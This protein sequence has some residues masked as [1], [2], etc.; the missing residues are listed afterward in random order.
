MTRDPVD[1]L[2]ADLLGRCGIGGTTLRDGP[3]EPPL[4]SVNF[5]ASGIAYAMYRLAVARDDASL[6]ALA[7]AWGERAASLAN[8]EK[9]FAGGKLQA[10]LFHSP[11]GMHAVRA[12]VGLACGRA[13]RAADAISD[14]IAASRA[15]C[16]LDDLSLGRAG[17]LVGCAELLEA[18]TAST[19]CDPTTILARGAELREAIARTVDAGSFATSASLP[20]LGL[21]HGWAG[22]LFALL[23]WSRAC[24]ESA[25]RYRAKVD[26]LAPLHEPLGKGIRWPECNRT[27]SPPA[28]LPGWCHGVA[29]HTLFWTLAHERLGGSEYGVLA[30][31]SATSAWGASVDH[32]TLCCGL[33]GIGYA[34]A[35]AHRVTGDGAWL[36]RARLA[37][38]FACDDRSASFHRDSLY[39]GAVGVVLLHG[40][41]G[42][43]S[44]AAPLVEQPRYPTAS[45]ALRSAMSSSPEARTLGGG[46]P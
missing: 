30:E 27:V 24:G 32:G 17:L 16:D 39:N 19:L 4:A 37:A 28:Y 1:Q 38:R 43:S 11:S 14:F 36:G 33:A 12:L 5:G 13:E 21:A 22:L 26:E 7:D 25:E 45:R 3:L 2:A 35:A 40:E 42:A 29:G 6:L 34:C 9:A 23:R 18:I 46:S 44:P 10:S 8:H 31:R 15:P 41:L 20:Y